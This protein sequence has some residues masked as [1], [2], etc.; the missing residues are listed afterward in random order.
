M[1]K[2]GSAEAFARYHVNHNKWP[3][4]GYHYVI[5]TDGSIDFTNDWDVKSY[6]VGNSNKT[7]IG[8]CLVGNF[9]IDTPNHAQIKATI[10]LCRM[11]MKKIPSIEKIKGHNEYDGYSWKDCPG[12][13]V[14]E[15]RENIK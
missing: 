8:V 12:F 7:A 9:T 4:I 15:I 10:E 3:G 13:D 11:L 14:S 5:N 2:Q 1:T 6:H